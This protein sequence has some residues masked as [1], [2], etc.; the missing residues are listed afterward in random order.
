MHYEHL[1]SYPFSRS[2]RDCTEMRTGR[3]PLESAEG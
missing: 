3:D 1:E 2:C